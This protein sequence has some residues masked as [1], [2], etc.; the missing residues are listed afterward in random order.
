MLTWHSFYMLTL[1]PRPAVR[2]GMA[3]DALRLTR[4]LLRTTLVGRRPGACTLPFSTP[5]TL[6]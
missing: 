1:T 4:P 3:L 5:S 2:S 6:I